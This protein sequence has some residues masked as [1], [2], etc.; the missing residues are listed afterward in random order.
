MHDQCDKGELKKIKCCCFL[1]VQVDVI[2]DR[3]KLKNAVDRMTVSD[4]LPTWGTRHT[5][6]LLACLGFANIYAM[7]VNLNVAIVAMVNQ[8][9]S[10]K[11]SKIAFTKK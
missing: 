6:S 8:S 3:P 7:R 9:N 11:I 5:F 10:R 1:F 4:K 2:I